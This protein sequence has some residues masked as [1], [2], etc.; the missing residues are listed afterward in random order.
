M[1]GRGPAGLLGRPRSPS[2]PAM[3]LIL[4]SSH[5]G[6]VLVSSHRGLILVS[7]QRGRPGSRR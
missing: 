1:I 4:M 3:P 5:R 7:S 6:L 2:R